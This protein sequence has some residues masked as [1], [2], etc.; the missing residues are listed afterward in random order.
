MLRVESGLRSRRVD[1]FR[2]G[3]A[4][5]DIQKVAEW[6]LPF[7]PRYTQSLPD[8]SLTVVADALA[9]RN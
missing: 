3:E 2:V 7:A 4:D 6:D 5:D 8:R 9:I 1:T